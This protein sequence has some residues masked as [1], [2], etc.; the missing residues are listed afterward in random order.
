MIKRL[1]LIIV[2]VIFITDTAFA[3]VSPGSPT[4]YVN[5]YSGVL[6]TKTKQGTETLLSSFKET[7][8]AEVSV[9][10][11]PSLGGESIENYALNLGREWGIGAKGKDNGVLL[12]IAKDD[13]ELRIEVGYGLEGEL[14][15]AKSSRI[16]RDIIT[17]RFKEGNY[18]AG[19]INGVREIIG[20]IDPTF[21][22][23]TQ[24]IVYPSGANGFPQSIVGKYTFLVLL[25]PFLFFLVLQWFVS[26]LGRTKSWWL[27]GLLGFI[28]GGFL[29]L[30]FV[31]P[32]A[33]IF[34]LTFIGLFFDF[35]V[36][37]SYQKNMANGTQPPWWTGGGS[38]GGGSSLGKS[39]G[40]GFSGGSFGGGGASG[41]W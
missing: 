3:Y 7:G 24:T 17:P 6:S 25:L 1:I 38:S 23:V 33:L 27:G 35:V 12:L 11:I 36:S 10:V 13:R 26:I 8:K 34:F 18:D 29:F 15:D 40:G 20:V 22:G 28:V 16:I 14:T 21:S 4:G 5:D 31:T 32:L 2:S 19:V 30:K 39:S 37:R 9:V 41:K